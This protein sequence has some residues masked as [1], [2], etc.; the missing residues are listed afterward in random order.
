MK[1]VS[2][3]AALCFLLL[4]IVGL[5]DTIDFT[6]SAGGSI[7][8]SGNTVGSSTISTTGITIGFVQGVLVPQ[9]QT[10]APGLTVTSGT[11]A[12]TGLYSGAITVAGVYEY[13]FTLQTLTLSGA[14]PGASINSSVNLLNFTAGTGTAVVVATGPSGWS[15]DMSGSPV[16]LNAALLSWFG[17][18]SSPVWSLNSS[19]NTPEGS[20]CAENNSCGSAGFTLPPASQSQFIAIN[21]ATVAPE[22]ASFSLLGLGLFGLL[23]LWRRRHEA[24]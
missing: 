8:V 18:P 20:P 6:G 2:L 13:T 14:V 22:P 9:N 7:T 21:S 24:L 5:A 23:G 15:L 10:G 19:V 16:T 17:A 12:F 4:P 11:L 3:I 1:R